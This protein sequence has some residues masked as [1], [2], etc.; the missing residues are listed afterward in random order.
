MN[1]KFLK[2]DGNQLP[3]VFAYI[4]FNRIDLSGSDANEMRMGAFYRDT[5]KLD[6]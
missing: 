2:T 6:A 1:T 4:S 3:S 5:A